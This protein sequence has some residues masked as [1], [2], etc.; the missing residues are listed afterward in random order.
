MSCGS[1]HF[2]CAPLKLRLASS[3]SGTLGQKKRAEAADA[4]N[5]AEETMWLFDLRPLPPSLKER[6]GER[7][8]TRIIEFIMRYCAMCIESANQT[9]CCMSLGGIPPPGQHFIIDFPSPGEY[10][11]PRGEF[12]LAAVCCAQAAAK[13]VW[14]RNTNRARHNK[15]LWS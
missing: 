4:I 10:Q 12:F 2:R 5:K 14:M 1:A 3:R 8:K 13:S 7:K 6:E 11:P 15:Q 9:E